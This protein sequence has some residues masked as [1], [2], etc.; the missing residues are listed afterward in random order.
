MKRIAKNST[1]FKDEHTGI[2]QNRDSSS[3]KR[4]RQAKKRVLEEIEKRKELE[5]RMNK[6]ETLVESLIKEK[7]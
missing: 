3:L 2:V 6:L 5:D 7:K 4:A 1:L